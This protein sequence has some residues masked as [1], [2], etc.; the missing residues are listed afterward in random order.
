MKVMAMLMTL[1]VM[2]YVNVGRYNDR[3]NDDDDDNT[4]L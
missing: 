4:C 1:V 2:G 3:V